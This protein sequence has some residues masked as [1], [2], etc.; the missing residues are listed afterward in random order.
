MTFTS[1]ITAMREDKLLYEPLLWSNSLVD[2]VAVDAIAC[3]TR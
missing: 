1:I 2:M 3:D